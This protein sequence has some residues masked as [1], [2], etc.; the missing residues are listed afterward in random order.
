MLSTMQLLAMRD[1]FSAMKVLQAP[2]STMRF[3]HHMMEMAIINRT[4]DG[5]GSMSDIVRYC[6]IDYMGCHYLRDLL[7]LIEKE[8][9]KSGRIRALLL[10]ETTLRTTTEASNVSE[11][12]GPPTVEAKTSCRTRHSRDI[13][14]CIRSSCTT[15]H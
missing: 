10:H 4:W 6:H 7:S 2:P 15:S 3:L 8:L 1:R 11:P 13:G 5:N 9:K 12:S 14:T